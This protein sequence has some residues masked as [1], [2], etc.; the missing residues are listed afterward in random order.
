MRLASIHHLAAHKSGGAQVGGG[1]V[2]GRE[3]KLDD[4]DVKQVVKD[5]ASLHDELGLFSTGVDSQ[6][7]PQSQVRKEMRVFPGAASKFMTVLGQGS[8]LIETAGDHLMAFTKTITEPAQAMAPW[9]CIRVILESSAVSAWLFQP[10]IDAKTRLKRS[11]AFRYEGQC[12]QLAL[13]RAAQSG[14]AVS[15]VEKRIEE[16]D[17]EARQMGFEQV[18]NKRGHRTGI[19][20]NMPSTSDLVKDLLGEEFM[21][22]LSSAMTHGHPMALQQLSFRLSDRGTRLFT[23]DS[24][25]PVKM[26]SAEKYVAPIS[27]RAL[28]FVAVSSLAM[29]VWYQCQLFGWDTQRLTSILDRGFDKLRI[30]EGKRCWRSQGA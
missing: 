30:A 20:Q 2:S 10:D 9:T 21:Y 14:G 22:R 6:P 11:F 24:S 29:P 8:L 5:I 3:L 25:E 19:A 16:I 18:L 26:S 17:S 13:V 12:Q 15:K 1:R 4:I 23:D 28:T 27:I 7:S